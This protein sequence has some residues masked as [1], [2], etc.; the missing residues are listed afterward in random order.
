VS[1]G[2]SF[3]STSP[4]VRVA[5]RSKFPPGVWTYYVGFRPSRTYH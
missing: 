2:G 3:L 5:Y 4:Y 1:R